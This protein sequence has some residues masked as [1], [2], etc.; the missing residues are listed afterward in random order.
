[1]KGIYSLSNTTNLKLHA[2]GVED[3][4]Q[5]WNCKLHTA[6]SIQEKVCLY[7]AWTHDLHVTVRCSTDETVLNSFYMA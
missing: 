3:E 2:D 6:I 5:T 7:E 1:M 4:L